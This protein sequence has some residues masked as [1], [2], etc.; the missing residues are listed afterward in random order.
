MKSLKILH[1]TASYKPAFV[2]GG[3]IYATAELCEA[4]VRAGH[5]VSVIT[6]TANGETELQV[7]PGKVYN[8]QGVDVQYYRRLTKDHTHFSPSLFL[9]VWHTCKKYDVVHIHSW[10]NLVSVISLF[11]CRLRHVQPVLTIRGTMSLHTFANNHNR[12]KQLFHRYIGKRLLASAILHV[13]SEKEAQEC[14]SAIPE[15]VIKVIPNLLPL[16]V[17]SSM[18]GKIPHSHLRLLF[19]GRIHPVKNLE[20]LL[21]TLQ[22]TGNEYAWKLSI[23]GGG[24]EGYVNHL[25]EKYTD[26]KDLEWLGEMNGQAKFAKY[27]EADV[28]VLLSHTENFGNV[29]LEALSCGTAVIVSNYVGLGAYIRQ[30]QFGWVVESNKESLAAIFKELSN[31]KEV[32]DRIRLQAP[33]RI[34]QDF[35]SDNLVNAYLRMYDEKII[36]RG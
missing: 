9:K 1:I 3:P 16:P 35:N 8:L 17:K 29:I 11:I 32:L 20:L 12:G 24:E 10:W 4:S 30:H 26:L 19:V 28:L 23:M 27:A 18:N 15:A 34:E 7:V 6:T 21:D 5:Q 2:Y 22:E 36:H 25:K 13:T 31:E 14:R 33:S